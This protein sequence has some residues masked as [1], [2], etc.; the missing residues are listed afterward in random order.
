MDTTP[1]PVTIVAVTSLSASVGG[2]TRY[3]LRRCCMAAGALPG[4]H[5][6]VS[7][8]AHGDAVTVGLVES[9]AGNLDIFGAT[10][11]E[12]EKRLRR[13]TGCYSVDNKE[14]RGGKGFN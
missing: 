4:S 11:P 6:E 8:P 13:A 12:I 5:G 7:E 3:C 14:R 10:C 2:P 9:A 1:G